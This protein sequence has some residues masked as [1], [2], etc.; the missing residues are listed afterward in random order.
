MDKLVE[1]K[2]KTE[3]AFEALASFRDEIFRNEQLFS[4]KI[5]LE[6]IRVLEEDNKALE[7]RGNST[8]PFESIFTQFLSCSVGEATRNESGLKGTRVG[9]KWRIYC[10]R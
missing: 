4:K 3:E 5:E 2:Q 1:A 7:N 6:R 10:V 9:R 8:R